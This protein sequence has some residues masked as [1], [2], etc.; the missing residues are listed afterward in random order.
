MK[1]FDR[2]QYTGRWYEH[3][4]DYWTEY[5]FWSDCVTATYDEL[6]TDSV[7]VTN[8]GYYWW[9]LFSYWTVQGEASCKLKNAR[10]KVNFGYRDTV[11][12]D[13]NYLVLDTDYK[14]YSIVY[15]C[16]R[17]WYGLAI[18]ETLWILTRKPEISAAYS[19]EIMGKVRKLVPS[20]MGP[21]YYTLQ[22]ETTNSCSYV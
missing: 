2:S 16:F 14:S 12:L 3:R 4:R 7:K 10:C 1:D 15:S 11:D 22:G 6:G 13:D 17:T 21:S 5:E 19:K 8:R 18:N 20:Y 9:A